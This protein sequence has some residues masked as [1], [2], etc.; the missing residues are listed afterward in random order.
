MQTTLNWTKASDKEPQM[1]DLPILVYYGPKW[2][3]DAFF[4][5]VPIVLPDYAL[6]AKLELPPATPEVNDDA[7]LDTVVKAMRE[8]VIAMTNAGSAEE[9]RR[10]FNSTYIRQIGV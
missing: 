10:V 5:H 2:G 8:A 4:Y 6:W 9:A 1:A 7:M 3:H